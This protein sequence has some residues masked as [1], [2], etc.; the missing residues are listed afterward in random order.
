MLA[1]K[2]VLATPDSSALRLVGLEQSKTE[3]TPL[4]M[5]EQKKHEQMVALLKATSERQAQVLT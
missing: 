4:K 2:R 1:T 5:A 3:W